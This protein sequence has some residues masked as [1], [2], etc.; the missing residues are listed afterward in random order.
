MWTWRGWGNRE[1]EMEMEGYLAREKNREWRKR[2]SS[3]DYRQLF[4]PKGPGFSDCYHSL[5]WRARH[6]RR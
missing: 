4:R 1:R 3:H 5:R 6:E 2:K